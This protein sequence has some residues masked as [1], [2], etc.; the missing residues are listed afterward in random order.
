MAFHADGNTVIDVGAATFAPWD[1]MVDVKQ[2]GEIFIAL[3]AD[4]M[5]AAGDL[6]ALMRAE[7]TPRITARPLRIH[8]T[9]ATIGRL[10]FRAH[11]KTPMAASAIGV[12][13]SVTETMGVPPLHQHQGGMT[14]HV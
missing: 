1:H 10:C 12:E 4:V 6:A 11:W 14:G 9:I 13:P 3:H 5:L 7:E 8:V 2:F